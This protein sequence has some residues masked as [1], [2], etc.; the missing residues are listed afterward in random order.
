[1]YRVLIRSKLDYGCFIYDNTSHSIKRTLD[2]VHHSAIRIATGAFRTTPVDSLLADAHEPPLGLRR[3]ALGMRYALKLRQFP[4]HPS[5]GAVY[6]SGFRSIFGHPTDT[7]RS[8]PAPFCL[9]MQTLFAESGIRPR[10]VIRMDSHVVG[11]P[12]W[13]LVTPEVDVSLAATRKRDVPGPV[14]KA[15]ALEH[16]ASYG[17]CVAC[18]TD[19]SKTDVG[20][21]CAFVCDGS[22]RSFT[23][24]RQTSVFT[25]ELVAIQKLLCY[26]EVDSGN[27]Y[28]IMSDSLSSLMALRSFNPTGPIV[29]DILQKLTGLAR[30]GKR[31]RLCWIPSHVGIQ[32]NET[33]DLAARR[34]SER[35]HLH[36]FPLPARDFFPTIKAFLH[37]KWQS[38]WDGCLGNKLLSLKPTLAP[39]ASSMRKN[40][41]DEVVLCRLTVIE[42]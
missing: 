21:G 15:G 17:D 40:R 2:T 35:P 16:I 5:Y 7:R 23:L 31:V 1:M 18:Y 12:P 6:S 28:L 30:E 27:S 20:V 4:F 38:R 39:W 11:T 9:R 36:R 41:R 3:E 19:G 13:R 29:Q 10:D 24:P 34:A 33:A 32:G 8:K 37:S 22:V 26:I 42:Y 25:S 14:L